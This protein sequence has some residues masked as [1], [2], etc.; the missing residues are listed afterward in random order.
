MTKEIKYL[1]KRAIISGKNVAGVAA[2][3]AILANTVSL[4]AK[5]D[6][7]FP[8]CPMP[9]NI[10]GV[11][12]HID[13]EGCARI[14]AKKIMSDKY[15]KNNK[16][17]TCDVYESAPNVFHNIKIPGQNGN[18]DIIVENHLPPCSKVVYYVADGDDGLKH[19]RFQCDY[20]RVY[21]MDF[22]TDAQ[23]LNK[24]GACKLINEAFL[25]T[26]AR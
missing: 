26:R 24:Y 6:K 22:A 19:I 20:A 9:E 21:N 25:A 10:S 3:M 18:Q 7:V 23:T 4:Q 5:E 13:Y 12:Y 17:E 14:N 15:G 1:L 11:S 2:F 16:Y 8:G